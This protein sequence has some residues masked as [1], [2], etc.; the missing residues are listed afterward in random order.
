MLNGENSAYDLSLQWSREGERREQG[1][2][3]STLVASREG[4]WET[5]ERERLIFHCIPFVTFAFVPHIGINYSKNKV[6]WE[7]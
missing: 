5:D 1:L 6:K 7:K 2:I 4:S 3:L